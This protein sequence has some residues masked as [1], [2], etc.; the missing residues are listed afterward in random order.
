MKCESC[1]RLIKPVTCGLCLE[2]WMS[3][4]TDIG[5]I[6]YGAPPAQQPKSGTPRNPRSHPRS[7]RTRPPER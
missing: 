7:P 1:G 5:L 3:A 4:A 2:C 6:G